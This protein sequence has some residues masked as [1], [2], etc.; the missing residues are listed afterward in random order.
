[1]QMGRKFLVV[2]GC[3]QWSLVKQ[4]S[5]AR[6]GDMK[7]SDLML[8]FNIYP[9]EDK[10]KDI[11]LLKNATTP[12]VMPCYQIQ[13]GSAWNSTVEVETQIMMY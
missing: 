7:C 3:L 5:E 4:A 2:A 8:N 13:G 10:L 9:Q 1:M 6:K 12:Q 11:S